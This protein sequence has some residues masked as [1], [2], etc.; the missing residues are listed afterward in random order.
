MGEVTGTNSGIIA[1][2]GRG[3][4][5]AWGWLRCKLS[6]LRWNDRNPGTVT[7]SILIGSAAA[8]VA[9]APTGDITSRQSTTIPTSTE[10]LR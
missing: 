8:P 2:I 6:F 3:V 5:F 9:T 7:G 4:V 1:R 10:D